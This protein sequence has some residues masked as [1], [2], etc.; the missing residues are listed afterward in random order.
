MTTPAPFRRPTVAAAEAAAP[1]SRSVWLARLAAAIAVVATPLLVVPRPVRG[2][3]PRPRLAAVHPPGGRQGS[4]VEVALVGA[5]LDDVGRLVFSHPGITAA[6]V[7]QPAGE[8]DPEPRPVP[9]KMLV[10]IAADVPPGVHDVFAAGRF[11][12]SNPRAFAVGTLPEVAKRGAIDTP[13]AALAIPLD[14]NVSARAQAGVA[15]HYAV[16]LAAGQRLH[17]E[18]WAKRLDSRMTALIEVLDPEGREIAVERGFDADDPAVDLVAAAAGRHV[19]RVHDLHLSGGDE[20]FYRLAV[21]TGP[22]VEG[23]FPPAAVPGAAARLTVIGRGLPGGS[24]ALGAAG[25]AGA[26][27]QVQVDARL[28][29]PARGASARTAWRLLSPRD[30]TA[31]LVDATGGVLASADMPPPVLAAAAPVV[32]EADPNDDPQKP[33]SLAPPTTVAG[34]FFPRGDRDWYA[35]AAKAGEKLVFDLHSRRL[36]LPTDAT[37]LVESVTAD[38]QGRPVSKEI[39]FADD[40]PAEFQGAGVGRGSH[41]PS[42]VFTAPADGTYRVLVRELGTDSQARLGNAYVLEVRRPDPDFQ[43]LTLLAQPDRADANKFRTAAPLLAAGGTAPVDVLVVKQDGFAGDVTVAAEGLPAGVTAQ[44]VLVPAKGNRATLVLVAAA[45]A[46]PMAGTFRVVGRAKGEGGELAR[47]ARSATLRWDVEAANRPQLLR[48]TSSIPLAVVADAAPVSVMPGEAKL[49]ETARGGKLTIPLTVVRRP[50]AKGPLSLT[51]ANLPAELK[52]PE[53]KIEE[54]ATTATVTVDCEPKLAAGRY[55]LVLKGVVK[56]AFAR[57]PQ[58]AERARADAGR[59]AEIAKQRAAR[60]A[61]A[62]EEL[63]AAEKRLADAQAGGATPPPDVVAAKEAAAKAVQEA[64]AAAKAADEERVRR[65]K[66][67]ADAAT[68]SAVKDIDVP[69]VVPPIEISVAETPV[70]TT[71]APERVVVKAGAAADLTVAVERKYGFEG[72]VT[73]EAAAAPAVAGVTVAAATVPADQSQGVLKVATTAATP[74]G[75]YELVLKGKVSFFD[76]EIVG[77]RRVPLIVEAPPPEPP[78]P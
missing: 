33:Q 21:T 58:A 42:L 67:A 31:E 8:F 64:D 60:A 24:P 16:A 11:G 78:K 52:V 57:N 35:F 1:R 61:A 77:E 38:A 28:G 53:T 45:D 46:P 51:A 18:A 7:L 75:T 13:A 65:E 40:G 54:Q 71:P 56:L 49:W 9:G 73:L 23:V 12:A 34:R 76:R 10:T 4:T 19:V 59:V 5:D 25:K 44:P 6:P 20:F 27:E 15:D 3:F 69:I 62:K 41:D 26:V 39:A 37:L 22:V 17:V 50:G 63:V 48:E 70:V 2:E 30:T 36:G 74:P 14:A 47:T 72:P 66:A 68:A 32:T 43:L 55:A 29:D